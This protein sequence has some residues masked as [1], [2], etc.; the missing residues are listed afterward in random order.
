MQ[1]LNTN[2]RTAVVFVC[3]LLILV[4]CA[5]I[6]IQMEEKLAW[7]SPTLNL[8]II[9]QTARDIVVMP[10][11]TNKTPALAIP[12]GDSAVIL[13]KAAIYE[14]IDKKDTSE[15]KQ[16]I[17]HHR[18]S[19]LP[20]TPFLFESGDDYALRIKLHGEIYA[21]IIEKADGWFEDPP[22]LERLS[23][24]IESPPMAGMPVN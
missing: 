13:F 14:A 10:V 11:D 3:M 8:K 15:P 12:P 23:I 5:K 6:S 7:E 22:I 24:V 4:S 19:A 21:F 1:R 2:R 20:E 17:K 18:L 9:N 16:V